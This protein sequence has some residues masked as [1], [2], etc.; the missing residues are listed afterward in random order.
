MYRKTLSFCLMLAVLGGFRSARAEMRIWEEKS[1]LQIKGEFVRELF[2]EIEL[3]RPDGS[4]YSIPVKNLSE[5]DAEY[6]RTVIPPEIDLTVRKSEEPKVRN[7]KFV[8]AGDIMTTITIEVTARKK[9]RAPFNG[10]LR[11]EVYIVG[12]EVATDDYTLLGKSTSRIIFTDENKGRFTFTAAADSHVYEE[13]NE[14]EI[15]GAEY[16]GYVVVIVDALGNKLQVENGLSWLQDDHVD[17]LRRFYVG[18]F[19]DEMCRKRSVPRPK[20]YEDRYDFK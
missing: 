3:R 9:S 17:K 6:V 5:Q 12:K 18:A 13:Y 15:R 16:S 11:A 14:L 7:E 10:V 4:L 19:F 8:R 2:G 20:Y 1:G